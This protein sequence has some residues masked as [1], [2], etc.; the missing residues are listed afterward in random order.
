MWAVVRRQGKSLQER[1]GVESGVTNLAA[2]L[3]EHRIVLSGIFPQ[4]RSNSSCVHVRPLVREFFG[5][6]RGPPRGRK[7]RLKANE[8]GETSPVTVWVGVN[9]PGFVRPSMLKTA[10]EPEH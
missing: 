1:E 3:L 5:I 6:K 10:T 8:V 2:R 7:L 9:A 4:Q